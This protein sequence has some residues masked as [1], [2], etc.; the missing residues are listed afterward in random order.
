MK[1]VMPVNFFGSNKDD[2]VDG[3][4]KIYHLL[5]HHNMPR[6]FL[7]SLYALSYL[8]LSITQ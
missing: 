8:I 7:S 6:P 1:L 5:R 4:D 3:N 2:D